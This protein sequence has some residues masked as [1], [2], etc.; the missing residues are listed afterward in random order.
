MGRTEFLIP[1]IRI[2]PRLERATIYES[3]WRSSTSA[4]RRVPTPCLTPP[5]LLEVAIFRKLFS[6]FYYFL[7][8]VTNGFVASREVRWSFWEFSCRFGTCFHG[9]WL[10]QL[11]SLLARPRSLKAN[12]LPKRRFALEGRAA[13]TTSLSMQRVTVSMS[14]AAHTRWS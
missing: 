13:S 8:N 4:R 6:F 7:S 14:R 5:K 9:F 2:E 12:G 10:C 11:R 1:T 3:E